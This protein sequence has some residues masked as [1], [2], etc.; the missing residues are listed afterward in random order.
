MSRMPFPE[1]HPCNCNFSLFPCEGD[2]MNND[3]FDFFF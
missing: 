3:E 2:D 1:L